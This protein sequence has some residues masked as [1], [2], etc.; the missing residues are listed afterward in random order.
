MNN[1]LCVE[2]IAKDLWP[3][4][5]FVPTML[6]ESSSLYLSHL[7]IPIVCNSDDA[8]CKTYVNPMLEWFLIGPVTL[9]Q[10]KLKTEGVEIKKVT[11]IS[12]LVL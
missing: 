4:S 8:H 7:T 11:P 5:R 10:S 3:F 12:V 2:Q 9:I 1:C 6:K